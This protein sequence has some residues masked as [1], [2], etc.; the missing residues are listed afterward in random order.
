M[1]TILHGEDI[2]S[3]RNE[4][5][6][7]KEKYKGRILSFEDGINPETIIQE[8]EGGALFGDLEAVFIENLISG[9]T[10]KKKL[11]ESSEILGKIHSQIP[12]IIWEKKE[13]GKTDLSVFPKAEVKIFKFPKVIFSF[14]DSIEPGKGESLIKLFHESLKASNENLILFMIIK[15]LRI[16]IAISSGDGKIDEV[17]YLAPWQEGR[18]KSQAKKFTEENLIKSYRNLYEIDLA[19]KTGQLGKTLIQALDFWLLDI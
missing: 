3:S 15:R 4:F 17:K 16:L 10:N 2:T 12:V 8:T 11:K 19:S 6:K 1:I 5:V 14:L 9:E 7:E 13:L 18:L